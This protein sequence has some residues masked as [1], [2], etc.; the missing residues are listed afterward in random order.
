M[1]QRNF[2]PIDS[3]RPH[4]DGDTAI[5][6]TCH[7]PNANYGLYV[8]RICALLIHD[9]RCH[10]ACSVAAGLCFRTVNVSN[11]HEHI[12]AWVIR[13]FQD[14]NQSVPCG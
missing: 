5:R 12:G 6:V 10:A 2:S 4:I 8:K 3:G 14:Q 1:G 7:R 11:F 13:R 9:Q